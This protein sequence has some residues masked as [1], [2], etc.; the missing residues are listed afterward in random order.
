MKSRLILASVAAI[1][2]GAFACGD[3]STESNNSNNNTTTNNS[4][5]NATTGT[6]NATNNVSDNTGKVWE[7]DYQLR[8]DT[9]TFDQGTAAVGLNAILASNFNQ[10]LDF[11]VVVLIDVADIATDASTATI[12]GGSGLKTENA[13]EYSWDPD[14]DDTYDAATLTG[15][16]GEFKGVLQNLNFVATFV[17]ETD[18]QK[19]VIPIQKLEVS[20]NITLSDDA[21]TA[22]IANGR[23]SGFVTQADG[24]ATQITLIPGG[25]PVSIAALFK[26][27]NLNYNS[28]TGEVVMKGTGD[29]WLLTA[30]FT[31]IPTVIAGQ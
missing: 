23:M 27:S 21:S 9:L 25:A 2:L 29:S 1:A 28:A 26:T 3:D 7:S 4:S 22:S 17:T 11:P 30:G 12:R 18:T 24:E 20:G 14:G 19:V 6:N 13:G 10:E 5:N 16:T 8:F 15:D 31:A